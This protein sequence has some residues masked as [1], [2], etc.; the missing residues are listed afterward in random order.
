[1][2]PVGIHQQMSPRDGGCDARHA[3]AV[4]RGWREARRILVA[5]ASGSGKT[6]LARR[7]AAASGTAHTEIDALHWRPGWTSNP[8][9]LDDVRAL[10]AG[11]AWVTEFQ[12][13]EAQP[14]L[15]ARGELL[16]WLRPSRPVVLLRVVRRTLVRRMRGEL[17]WGTN[18]EPPLRT[19]LTDRDHIVRWSMRTFH[20]AE[21][22]IRTARREHPALR[23]VQVRSRRDV[24][25]L[26]ALLADR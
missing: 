2:P 22:R 1:M 19:V 8:V 11:D 20:A 5:G 25:R 7:I 26:L 14:I 17:V 15:A 21:D 24:E 23:L 18:T 4:G 6:T 9:F 3:G 12:Y 16:V 13:R 10:A